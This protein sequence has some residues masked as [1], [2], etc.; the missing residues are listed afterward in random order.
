ML[1]LFCLS[2]DL[3]RTGKIQSVDIFAP[4]QTWI[5]ANVLVDLVI[6]FVF[7]WNLLK[8]KKQNTAKRW[9]TESRMTK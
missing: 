2:P 9:A 5:W 8:L 7:V 6:T 3:Y 1:M 4:T